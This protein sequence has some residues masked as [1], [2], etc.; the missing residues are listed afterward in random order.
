MNIKMPGRAEQKKTG[1]YYQVVLTGLVEAVSIFVESAFLSVSEGAV[2]LLLSET[3]VESVPV[4]DESAA[5]LQLMTKMVR[6]SITAMAEMV[7]F[8]CVAI[9]FNN[10]G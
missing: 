1:L 5:L 2:I 9:M 7:C 10:L 4:F 6:S 8:G 3:L